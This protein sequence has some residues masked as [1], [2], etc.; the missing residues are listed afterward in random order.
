[1]RSLWLLEAPLSLAEIASLQDW[2]TDTLGASRAQYGWVDERYPNR[3]RKTLNPTG[4]NA[5][6]I[7]LIDSD[8]AVTADILQSA[9]LN[10]SH[11]LQA[12]ATSVLPYPEV[13]TMSTYDFSLQLCCF[14]FI[15]TQAR[16]DVIDYWRKQHAPIACDNQTTVAYLQN[17]VHS[18]GPEALNI[19][20]WAEEGFPHDCID[21]PL[22]FFN[23]DNPATLQQHVQNI[24]SSSAKFIAMDS[25]FVQHYSLLRL[26]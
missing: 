20:G 1:M 13:D 25:I 23:A 19:D 9:P 7:V 2:L 12:E 16:G 22:R 18:R 8:Q 4:L 21:N 26:I 14:T 6:S 17:V 15:D 10:I 11:W 5:T 24:T 3:Q